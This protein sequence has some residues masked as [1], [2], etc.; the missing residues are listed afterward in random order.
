MI[1]ELYIYF[2]NNPNELRQKMTALE[3]NE[4]YFET[5]PVERVICDYIASMT[6][7]YVLG[8]YNGIFVP[9]PLV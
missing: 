4:A 3:M 5:T 7:R 6:D 8:L 9:T 1:S 2:L